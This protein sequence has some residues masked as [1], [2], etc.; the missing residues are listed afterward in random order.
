MA[1]A[2]GPGAHR[3][4]FAWG[5]VPRRSLDKA[6]QG[7]EKLQR[8]VE[9][10]GL[11]LRNS[12]PCLLQLLPQT[13]QHLL[14]IRGQPVASLNGLWEAGYFPVYIN[15]L[16]HKTK[17]TTKLFKGDPE[18]IFQEG[19]AS[20]RKLTKLSLIF[21][22]MLGELRALIP[23]GQDRGNQYQPN[24]PSAEAFWRGTWGTRSLVPW[25]EFQAGLQQ[26]HPVA[27]GP[28]A[29]ALRAT[30]DLTCSD[31]ISIFE[32]DVFTR[33]FQPWPT[34]LR[35]WTHLAVTHPAYVAFLTYDE[36]R[37]RLQPYTSKPGS[38]VFRLSCT[39][40][41]QWAIGYVSRDGSILQTIPQ[42]RPLFLALIEGHEEGFYLYPDGKNRN[43]DLRE[44]TEPMPQNRIEVSPD[45]A[46][47]YSQMGST[48]QLCKICAENDKDVQI[49]PCGHLLCSSCLTAWQIQGWQEIRIEP[50]GGRAV[51]GDQE[52]D[53]LEDVESVLQELAALR[54]VGHPGL[55]ELPAPPVPPRLDLLQ[56][57]NPDPTPQAP[58]VHPLDQPGPDPTDWI[59]H[60]PLPPH[61]RPRGPPASPLSQRPEEFSGGGGAGVGAVTALET[62]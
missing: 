9:Q 33:L 28:T 50:P 18:G 27:P 20:R 5:A 16:Q 45:Q 25:A 17:Q 26:V 35:N 40:L 21:S 6:L 51:A 62:G 2:G 34:L 56:P 32:F 58:P 10:P 8:L 24:Q 3:G 47:L 29:G 57:S 42:D 11:G 4:P 14:L 15:N 54:E 61:P 60:R 39:R 38:Y 43:P 55:S 49:Q 52:D 1:A 59:R 37:A 12:P 41:G 13:R 23:D 44:L 22:H 46:Q 48:F 30:M 19:S 36:V 53:D 7:L 31:H